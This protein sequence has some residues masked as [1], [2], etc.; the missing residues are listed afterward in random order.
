MDN[1]D[2]AELFTEQAEWRESK[3]EAFPNDDRN[4]DA[5]KLLRHLA[6]TAQI[7]PP[8]VIKAAEELYE[9]APDV[10]TWH[11]MIKQIGFH[12]FPDNAEKFLRD[13]IAARTT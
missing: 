2:L 10:E 6:D 3:A 12:R 4:L 7:V 9:D 11:E 5:A 1:S 13:Y 8:G